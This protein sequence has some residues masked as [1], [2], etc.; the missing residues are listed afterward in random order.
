VEYGM[1]GHI[2]EWLME[3]AT[4]PNLAREQRGAVVEGTQKL[5]RNLEISFVAVT[6][7]SKPDLSGSEITK[8]RSCDIAPFRDQLRIAPRKWLFMLA[9][10]A[11]LR[12]TCTSGGAPCQI[13]NLATLH[14]TKGDFE[15]SDC[16]QDIRRKHLQ[17]SKARKTPVDE[18]SI[19]RV[20]NDKDIVV[21]SAT[22]REKMQR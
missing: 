11:T 19:R 4:K 1:P 22:R 8:H 20:E 12:S 5:F 17:W 6:D 16:S 7:Q 10:T 14:C 21:N 9:A 13:P 2:S 18:E 3:F 15:P